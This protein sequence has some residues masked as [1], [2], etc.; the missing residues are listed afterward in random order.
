MGDNL[1]IGD[2]IIIKEVVG[3]TE[4]IAQGTVTAVT[5]STGAVTVSSWDTGSTFPTGGYTVNSTVFKWQ[6]EYFDI[7]GSLST[8]R[9]AVTKIV[10]KS[11]SSEYQSNVWIDDIKYTTGYLTDADATGNV[12]STLARY[13]K[14]KII[15]TTTD[16]DVTPYISQVEVGYRAE[17]GPSTEDLMRHGKWF[18]TSGV[19]QAFWWADS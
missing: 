14:Y 13:I 3:D 8:H 19:Q 5:S 10:F 7:S 6:V 18:N 12:L 15:F 4:Y 2:K 9:D 16:E 11:T 17:L 1:Y